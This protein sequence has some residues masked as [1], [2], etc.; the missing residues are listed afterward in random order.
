MTCS[1]LPTILLWLVACFAN[2]LFVNACS[3]IQPG[4]IETA[5]NDRD[6]NATLLVKVKSQMVIPQDAGKDLFSAD[7]R[8]KGVIRKAYRAPQNKED[9][10]IL[11]SRTLVE[12]RTT[13]DSCGVELQEN[14][15]YLLVGYLGTKPT[16]GGRLTFDVQACQYQ[17]PYRALSLDEK[18]Y[19]SNQRRCRCNQ[20]LCPPA[21]STFN[22]SCPDHAET[23]AGPTDTCRYNGK[24]R[25]CSF[26][27]ECPA[28]QK[29]DDCVTAVGEFCSNGLCRKAGTCSD[30]RDCLNPS[31]QYEIYADCDYYIHC[32]EQ[33]KCQAECGCGACPA[34]DCDGNC[35]CGPVPCFADPCEVTECNVDG[36]V[37]CVPYYCGGC[38][39]LLF[40]EAG[41]QPRC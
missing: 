10:D 11:Q 34:S 28:C 5:F 21:E 40:N 4:N 31:N 36:E 24:P 12:I 27:Q 41:A 18:R 20:D 14:T 6:S 1:S 3:C 19:L 25:E 9:C 29:D 17:V 39:A 33:G 26:M 16:A 7:V 35:P 23:M 22:F 8:Y 30:L 2:H 37:Q 13:A 32:S 38:Q 15:L